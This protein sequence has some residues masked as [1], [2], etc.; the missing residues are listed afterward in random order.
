MIDI[1]RDSLVLDYLL[2]IEAAVTIGTYF[3]FDEHRNRTTVGYL[4]RGCKFSNN[5]M[6]ES[7]FSSPRPFAS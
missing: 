1:S 4:S 6:T 7:P 3:L 5:S 2:R